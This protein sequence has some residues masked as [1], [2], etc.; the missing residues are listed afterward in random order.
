MSVLF[1]FSLCCSCNQNNMN[2]GAGADKEEQDVVTFTPFTEEELIL[3]KSQT[4]KAK[5]QIPAASTPAFDVW[6]G[7]NYCGDYSSC[8]QAPERAKQGSLLRLSISSV[9]SQRPTS[10]SNPTI[11]E[12]VCADKV[13]WLAGVLSSAPTVGRSSLPGILSAPPVTVTMVS[14][15]SGFERSQWSLMVHLPG[16]FSKAERRWNF[17]AKYA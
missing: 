5:M 15:C 8:T 1:L 13:I 10:E 12:A 11:K 16:N 14:P 7:L 3:F 9:T 17:K 2:N 6:G 4:S